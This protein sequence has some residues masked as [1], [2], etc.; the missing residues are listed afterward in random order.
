MVDLAADAREAGPLGVLAR[1]EGEAHADHLEWVGQEDGGH[2]R[3]GAREDAAPPGLVG[4]GR[5]EDGADLFVGEELGRRIGEDA[6]QRGRVATEESTQP[7][8]AVDVPH[9]RHDAEPCSRVFGEL[10]VGCLEEDF[11]AVERADY[12]LGLPGRKP[13]DSYAWTI[14]LFPSRT[15]RRLELLTAHPANPPARPLRQT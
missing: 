6:Q 1:L 8:L 10:R 2:A 9:G 12:G 14:A 15:E 4:G 7:V 13:L 3:D 5:D 11:D